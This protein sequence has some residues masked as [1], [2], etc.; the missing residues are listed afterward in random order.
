M[1]GY[2]KDET[3]HNEAVYKVLKWCQ[4]VNLK[5]NKD[6][7]HFTCTSIPFF[8]EVVSVQGIEPDLQK[9]RALTE[10]PVPKTKR[11]C[12]PF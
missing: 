10:M 1:I 7:C 11:N 9:V 6:K 12:R 8:A 4:D 3:D 5:L 2:N